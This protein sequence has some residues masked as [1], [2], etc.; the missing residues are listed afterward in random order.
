MERLRPLHVVV[1][2]DERDRNVAVVLDV[3]MDEC[4]ECGDRWLRWE[5]AG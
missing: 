5:I 1:V 3:P 2:V 4:P